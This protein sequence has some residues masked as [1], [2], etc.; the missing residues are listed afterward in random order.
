MLDAALSC[1]EHN[2]EP[3]GAHH[4]LLLLLRQEGRK[5]LGTCTV[6]LLNAAHGVRTDAHKV[7]L[8]LDLDEILVLEEA[9]SMKQDVELEAKGL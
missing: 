3:A 9:V 2:V 8:V 4:T 1:V 7:E 5:H 6:L